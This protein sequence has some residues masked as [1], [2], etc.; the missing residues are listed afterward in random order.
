MILNLKC[1][2]PVQRTSLFTAYWRNCEQQRSDGIEPLC[3]DPQASILLENFLDKKSE[4]SLRRLDGSPIKEEAIEMLAVRTSFIDDFILAPS[5][6]GL[7]MT[8]TFGRR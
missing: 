2:S 8:K 3:Y 5:K 7:E 6:T 4:E 1:L